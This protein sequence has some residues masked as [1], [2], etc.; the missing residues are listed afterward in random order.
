MYRFL[1][2]PRW[3]AGFVL[4]LL[5]AATMVRLGFWQLDRMHQKQDRNA[6]ISANLDADPQPAAEF[7]PAAADQRPAAADEWTKVSITGSYDESQTVLIRQRSFEEGVGYEIVV[8]F[9]A[10]DGRSYLVDR[11]YVVATAGAEV[12]PEVPPAPSGTVTVT[13]NVKRPYDASAAATRV[14]YV[15]DYKSVRALDPAVLSQELGVDLAGGY[16]TVTDEQPANGSA[17]AP[18]SRIPVPALDDGPHLSYAIQWWLFA[19]LTLGGFGYIVR[20]EAIDR[21]LAEEDLDGGDVIED[22][23]VPAASGV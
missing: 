11:G 6:A 4:V 16:V 7:I 9:V 5:A 17:V 21:L 14:E 22:D 3:I 2:S 1:T 12:A 20:R 10:D 19:L 13:G 18:I 8:P 23:D 15:G